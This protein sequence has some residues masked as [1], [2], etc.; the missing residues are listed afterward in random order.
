[1]KLP[2][3]R[4]LGFL[5]L[6]FAS[7]PLIAREGDP[8]VD[9]F[10]KE[11]IVEGDQP[12]TVSYVLTITAPNNVSAVNPATVTFNPTILNKPT[13]VS[14]SV[15]LSFVTFSPS[16]LT[17]TAPGQKLSVTINAEYPNGVSAGSYAYRVYTP[18]WTTNTQ[19][20]GFFI[21]AV[22][23]PSR[24][25]QPPTVTIA[26]PADGSTFTYRPAEGPLSIPVQFASVGDTLARI[27]AIDA[28]LNTASVAI[29]SVNT[30]EDNYTSTGTLNITSP[31]LYTLRA[32]ATNSVG[33]G[34]D[35]SEFRVLLE[36]PPP[37]VSI[38]SPLSGNS[39]PLSS[40]G[41]ASVPYSFV[42]STVYGGIATLTA[43]LNGNAVTFSP[44][45]IGSLTATG[46]GTFSL[47][48][49]GSYTLAVTTTDIN[50]GTASTSTTFTVVGALPPPT[51]AI[52]APANGTTIT[53]VAGSG[54]TSV[55]FTYVGTAA[56]GSVIT[57][58]LGS[59]SGQTGN[60]SATVTGI[61]SGIATGTGTLSIANAGTYTL[62][63]VATSNGATASASTTF[64]IVEVQ[65][66][67]P[68][69]SVNW[70]PPISLGQCVNVNCYLPIKFE[71]DCE[72]DTNTGCNGGHY[73][74]CN[75]RDCD[76]DRDDD[77]D[78]KDGK[79]SKSK[80]KDRDCDRDDDG[81]RDHYPGQ[82][83]KSKTNIDKTIVIA[84]SEIYS[85]GSTSDAQLFTYG[86]YDIQGND[87]Y[88]LNYRVKSGYRRYLVEVYRPTSNGV[89][90]LGS[91]EV[92]VR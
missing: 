34:E 3:I 29:T 65:P 7:L 82:R 48:T 28:D 55:P 74:N 71:L 46:S 92:R 12:L 81:D 62:T 61:N 35:T 57:S 58:L 2:L 52:S 10:P 90:V 27:T 64:T 67:P 42:G 72:D 13:G 14:D 66:P 17:F 20:G 70:L 76:K 23:F 19:D 6:S 26:T 21:N 91:R 36:V 60:V 1:M 32:R 77:R 75:D 87:M 86:D 18:G 47:T 73:G 44:A 5:A 37:T 54:P 22:V 33:T 84:V 15:A 24:N 80:S 56:S 83:T 41:T 69:C 4:L 51:V 30:S 43:T 31:G 59:L 8:I 53:R 79:K 45:G 50:G 9:Y 16:S 39:F 49:P 88:H 25:P 38:T 85:N 68:T 40:N 63:A 11:T 78:C 89:E